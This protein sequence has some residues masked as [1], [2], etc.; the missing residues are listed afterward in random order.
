MTDD[1]SASGAQ[2]PVVDRDEASAPFFD[3]ARDGRLV[4]RRCAACRR[5]LSPQA[6]SCGACGGSDL[7]WVQARG[8]ARLVTWAVVHRAP[9]DA[10]V[11]QVPYVAG[12]VRLAEGPWLPTR[13]VD[14][15]PEELRAGMPMRVAFV[16]PPEGE[17]YPVFVPGCSV[18][19]PDMTRPQT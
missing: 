6:T 15:D 4:I 8:D 11:D 1:S 16:H 3:A 5:L 17:S 9:H 7:D 12:Y 13:L 19:M 2:G 10:F 14:V 18:A